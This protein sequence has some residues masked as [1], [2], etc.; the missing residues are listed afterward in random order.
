MSDS[1]SK[2][3]QGDF[4]LDE[5]KSG[6]HV[7]VTNEAQ[8]QLELARLK[9]NDPTLTTIDVNYKLLAT[10]ELTTEEKDIFFSA[11]AENSTVKSLGLNYLSLSENDM[12]R[13]A[14]ALKTR[15]TG[16]N[17][18]FI[19]GNTVTPAVAK[20]L[21]T[22]PIDAISMMDTKINAEAAMYFV[23]NE[24]TV[25]QVNFYGGRFTAPELLRIIEKN[26]VTK[27]L[28][29]SSIESAV[30]GLIKP[31][32]EQLELINTK[33]KEMEQEDKQNLSYKK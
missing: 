11:L 7:G 20:I 24:A 23:E 12:L 21:S 32:K 30:G 3:G 14:E 22:L 25:K 28:D 15:K 26:K 13:L 2:N 18:L 27:K 31:S 10:D 9:S 6:P 33:V 5:E 8:K 1:R 19:Q 16:L 4:H 29:S 17:A